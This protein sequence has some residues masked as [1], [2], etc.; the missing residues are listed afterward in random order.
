MD[1]ADSFIKEELARRGVKIEY[2]L[3][4]TAVNK[5]K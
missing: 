4:L 1:S 3:N 2:G 5:E